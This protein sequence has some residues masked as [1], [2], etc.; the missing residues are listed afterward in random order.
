MCSC[1]TG[2]AVS[3]VCG[4]VVATVLS[5]GR[6]LILLL[7][8]EPLVI[9]GFVVHDRDLDEVFRQRRRLDLPLE[10]GSLPG[11]VPGYSPVLERPAEI[12]Q[13]QHVADTENG[14]AC[15]REH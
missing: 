8:L 3:C 11:I 1:S 6:H 9:V 10:P 12:Q 15:R 14:G 7:M 5:N 4:C 13:R 2:T